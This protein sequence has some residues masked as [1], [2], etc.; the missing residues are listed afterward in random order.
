MSLSFWVISWFVVGFL[1]ALYEYFNA[2]RRGDETLGEWLLTF[3]F[4]T[5][6]GYAGVI[7]TLYEKFTER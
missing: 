3:A 1:H 7:V 6:G 4:F 2:A 5:I